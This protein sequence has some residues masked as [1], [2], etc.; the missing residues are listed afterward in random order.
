MSRPKH[1]LD[2]IH[3]DAIADS[4]NAWMNPAAHRVKNNKSSNTS[5][6]EP[7]TVVINKRP[8][9]GMNDSTNNNDSPPYSSVVRYG[10]SSA[11]GRNSPVGGRNKRDGPRIQVWDEKKKQFLNQ[12]EGHSSPRLKNWSD[13]LDEF[14]RN[15]ALASRPLKI[16]EELVGGESPI[17]SP[18][19]FDHYDMSEGRSQIKDLP[20]P[21]SDAE[22][23]SHEPFHSDMNEDVYDDYARPA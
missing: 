10:N 3:D 21:Y 20:E 1:F 18:K 15:Q 16:I 4:L 11:S 13:R 23:S 7:S 8:A 5:Q 17:D 22:G 6:P 9:A 14:R 2:G 19:Q 12:Q